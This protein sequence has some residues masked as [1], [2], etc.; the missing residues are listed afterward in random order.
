MSGLRIIVDN[1]DILKYA[2]SVNIPVRNGLVR[3]LLMVGDNP[4]KN[5]NGSGDL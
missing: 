1:D 5:F 3:A 2:K 4:E